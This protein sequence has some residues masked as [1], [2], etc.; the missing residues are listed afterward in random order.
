MGAPASDGSTLR[1]TWVERDDGELAIGA[2]EPLRDRT[3]LG[4]AE[5]TTRELARLVHLTDAH[6]LDA[7]SPARVPF[8]ARFGGSLRSTFRPHEAL[9]AQVLHGALSAAR[10]EHAELLI[11][12]GDLIDNAQNNELTVALA[13]LN[14]GC[15]RPGSGPAGYHGVQLST[16]PD[17]AYYRPDIDPPRHPGLLA[18]ASEPFTSRGVGGAW[19]PVLG[20]HDALVQG[21]LVPT[22]LTQRV[23][24]GDRA[25]W[26]PP[27]AL[28]SPAEPGPAASAGAAAAAPPDELPE[29]SW[30]EAFIERALAGATVSIP[31]D[32]ARYEL[33]LPEVIARLWLASRA[34]APCG[35]AGPAPAPG[36]L[37]LAVDLGREVRIV[38]LDLVRRE[39][40]SGG[41]VA[42]EQPAWLEGQ[43]A[44]AADRWVI[45]CTHHPLEDVDGG[46]AIREVLDR[47]PRVAA[48]LA[49][50]THRNR[51]V[52]RETAAGG[53]WEITTCSLIDFPQQCRALRIYATASGGVAIRTW[54]LDHIGDG[55]LGAVAR[56]LAHRHAAGRTA[57]LTGTG[58]D[59][60]ATLYRRA[61]D[62]RSA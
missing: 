19:L 32:P 10:A 6:V 40:G 17:G 48:T 43:L 61:P 9:T 36:R 3:R 28:L 59:R 37:D 56:E 24:V 62:A 13:L 8:L 25:L 38:A 60:N 33:E 39:G 44:A 47:F 1:S 54:M 22:V 26:E 15:V 14:G 50:H 20:D 49:G 29:A 21:E 12:G 11:Q 31:P 51:I 52:A 55:H 58:W 34:S 30:V 41:L 46:E 7:S 4:A 53:Y 42:A 2:P 57:H 45:L 16:N 27:A 5:P 35:R 23:A 18:R